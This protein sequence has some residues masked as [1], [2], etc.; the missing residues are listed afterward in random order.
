MIFSP[1]F[2]SFLKFELKRK[3]EHIFILCVI[4]KLNKLFSNYRIKNNLNLL[5]FFL[6]I[7]LILK[8]KVTG[9]FFYKQILYSLLK[10]PFKMIKRFNLRILGLYVQ[11]TTIYFN[12]ICK[13]TN[14]ISHKYNS[15]F[16]EYL[17]QC[18]LKLFSQ[19]TQ[20]ILEKFQS[21][22]QYYPEIGTNKR[23]N[24]TIFCGNTHMTSGKIN[25]LLKM[26]HF[27]R[28]NF[29]HLFFFLNAPQF[30]QKNLRTFEND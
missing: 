12:N 20:T 8:S 16:L 21:E 24:A 30:K 4:C 9:N 1:K 19:F 11:W 3:P 10:L 5:L 28:E 7:E 17:D 23:Q 22:F 6:E 14:W 15:N 25:G 2:K 13:S 18:N 29:R 27:Y 26:T